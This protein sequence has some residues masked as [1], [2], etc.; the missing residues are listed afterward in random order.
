MSH[1]KGEFFFCPLLILLCQVI[2]KSLFDSRHHIG[3]RGL[4]RHEEPQRVKVNESGQIRVYHRKS[5]KPQKVVD[6]LDSTEYGEASEKA[7]GASNQTQL[8]LH[9]HLQMIK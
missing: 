3:S 6:D 5:K 8:G 4:E 9:C 7:H 2:F 1:R